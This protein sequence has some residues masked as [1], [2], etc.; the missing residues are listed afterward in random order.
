MIDDGERPFWRGALGEQM[1]SQISSLSLSHSLPL[2]VSPSLPLHD[3][4]KHRCN[5][6]TANIQTFSS[7]PPPPFI[8]I[9]AVKVVEK[10]VNG[11]R[12]T[13]KKSKSLIEFSRSRQDRW[14]HYGMFSGSE[15]IRAS[16]TSFVLLFLSWSDHKKTVVCSLFFPWKLDLVSSENKC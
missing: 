11:K 14:C 2:S 15:N 6:H 13:S 10:K 12:K 4:N 3:I 16:G 1:R 7:S 5:T 9:V 8:S